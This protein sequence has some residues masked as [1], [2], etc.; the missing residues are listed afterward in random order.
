MAGR[1]KKIIK[2]LQL[3]RGEDRDSKLFKCPLGSTLRLTLARNI[4]SSSVIVETD[5]PSEGSL[6]VR[7]KMRGLEWT[8]TSKREEWDPDRF[9]DILLTVPGPFKLEWKLSSQPP[10]SPPSPGH[11][12]FLVEPD[13]GLSPNSICCLTHITKLLGP[14]TE[15]RGRLSPAHQGGYNMLHFTPPQQ[16]GSSRSGYSIANQLKLDSSYLP[17][18][19]QR[20]EVGVVYKN[21]KGE[22]KTVMLDS[23]FLEMEQELKH[24]RE[25]CGVLS[26]VDVVWNHT[27]FDTPWLI[28]VLV[29]VRVL[30]GAYGAY[31]IGFSS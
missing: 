26:I 25:D 30:L 27:S 3:T 16:L 4:S 29:F 8:Y 15:W 2:T 21:R 20:Q 5:Y 6:Y 19:Y 17:S 12:F 18:G 14:L 23:A 1:D 11:G 28:Q 10:S 24:L 7:G 31:G 9:V 13:L 22:E